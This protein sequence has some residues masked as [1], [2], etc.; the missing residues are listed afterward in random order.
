M[1]RPASPP[2]VSLPVRS[3]LT[4]WAL[5]ASA[6]EWPRKLL[7]AF[8][9]FGLSGPASSIG[10]RTSGGRAP[11]APYAATFPVLGGRVFSFLER[12]AHPQQHSSRRYARIPRLV[13]MAASGS[14]AA[15]A[16]ETA[17]VGAERATALGKVGASVIFS[18]FKVR[19]F[20]LSI[21]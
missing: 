21:E 3:P 8:S 20:S 15:A 11:A 6:W 2:H 4:E 19:T 12:H 7:C 17:S 5:P 16:R 9:L 18:P 10:F 13:T 1:A 14:A